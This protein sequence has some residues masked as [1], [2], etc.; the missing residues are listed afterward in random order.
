MEVYECIRSRRTWRDYKA[1]AVPERVIRKILRAGRWSPSST[2]SQPWHFVVVTNRETIGELGR[3][4]TQGPFIATAPL[5]IAI[6]MENALRPHLD[7]GRALQQMELTAWEEG[8]GTCFV[9]LRAEEQQ[10][11]IKE[12]LGIPAE[13]ELI[14]V[15]PFGYRGERPAN[16]VG[17]PRKPLEE[18]AHRERFGVP[19]TTNRA[20][21][22]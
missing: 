10:A 11:A 4:A 18:M 9:G 5:V 3:I 14:T 8:L 12:L 20:G 17:T 7:A 13:L 6:A 15:L 16:R 21:R 19:Y 1:D 2:N 22:G